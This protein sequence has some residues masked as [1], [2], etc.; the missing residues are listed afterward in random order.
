M[1][2]KE[3]TMTTSVVAGT[4]I[5]GTGVSG[6][7]GTEAQAE[8]RYL[9]LQEISQMVRIIQHTSIRIF[10]RQGILKLIF[11][12]HSPA[13]FLINRCLFLEISLIHILMC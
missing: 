2:D 11:P 10:F 12:F 7:P 8:Y 6:I 4:P 13:P 5:G 3:N 9:Y 1:A